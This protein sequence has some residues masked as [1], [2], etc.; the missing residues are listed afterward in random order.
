MKQVL[1]WMAAFLVCQPAGYAEETAEPE[2]SVYDF[3]MKTIDGKELKL[4]EYKGKVLLIVNVAS[5]CG[6]TPQYKELVELYKK[7]HKQGFEILGFPANNFGQQEPGTDQEI[8][9]FCTENYDVNFPM[10]SKISVKGEDQHPLFAYLTK[11]PNPDFTDEIK[12]NFE[13]ILIGKDGKV[14]HRFRSKATPM[15][16][17]ITK[18]IEEALKQ[19]S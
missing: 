14:L 11:Q 10:F 2:K 5:K 1:I 6:Y 3:K 19:E 7:Y 18:A 13:K 12:W 15:G 9:V 17:E 16:E 8:K 4:S